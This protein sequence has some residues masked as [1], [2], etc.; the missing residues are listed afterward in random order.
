[1]SEW[2]E[3]AVEA[4]CSRVTSGGTP[5]RKRT[6]FYS[7]EGIPWVKSQELVGAR[8]TATEEHISEAGLKGSSAKLLPCET[9]LLAMYGANV[10][11]LGWLGVEATVNQ[12]ICA[13]VTD[14]RE[15]DSRFLYYALA[16]AR[17]RL[18]GKAHGA[19]QQNLSQQLIRPFKLVVPPLATQ[20]RIGAILRSV[21]DLIEN[22]R[23]RVEVLEEM[24]RAIY[25]E[26]FV[27]FRFPGHQEVPLADTASGPIPQ[28][29]QPKSLRELATL[30][31]GST[32]TKASY[33]DSGFIAFSAA[34]PDGL[35]PKFEVEG[36][37]VVLSAVGARCGRTFWAHGRWAVS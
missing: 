36:D 10:G 16:G 27:K 5:S 30:V 20:R 24:A 21:D 22:N 26:W 33:V 12:A 6:D 32:T 28:G 31:G 35:L 29:W 25:R 37:G 19:A 14:P 4:L 8:I 9:V 23:R 18:V 11:Q 2:R 3:L 34:G 7:V 13:M 1:M 15:T 17:E